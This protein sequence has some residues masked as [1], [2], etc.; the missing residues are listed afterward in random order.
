MENIRDCIQNG[1]AI[2]PLRSPDADSKEKVAKQI[3]EF[4][5]ENRPTAKNLSKCKDTILR[6]ANA[7]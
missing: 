6:I 7:Q 3:F 5:T 1:T 4:I 2:R